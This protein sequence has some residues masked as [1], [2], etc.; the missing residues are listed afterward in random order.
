MK[1][2]YVNVTDEQ[3]TALKQRAES[4]GSTVSEEIRR[5]VAAAVIKPAWERFYTAEE[6]EKWAAE[7]KKHA[8]IIAAT[9]GP[10]A[11]P[12]WSENARP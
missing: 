1:R 8:E 10:A 9:G 11:F 5:A 4:A 7:S 3:H 2:I 6:I 12:H